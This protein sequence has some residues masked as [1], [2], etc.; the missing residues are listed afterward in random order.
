MHAGCAVAR[1][2]KTVE[3]ERSSRPMLIT[4][5]QSRTVTGRYGPVEGKQLT[6]RC[7]ILGGAAEWSRK[8]AFLSSRITPIDTI[9]VLHFTRNLN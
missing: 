5:V 9:I 2:V 4:S 7:D 8:I 3:G 6:P 1:P